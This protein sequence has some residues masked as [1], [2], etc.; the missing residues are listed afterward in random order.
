MIKS[1]MQKPK[2]INLFLVSI[3]PCEEGGFFA[4]CPLL[5]G[6]HAEGESFAEA[7]ENIQDVIKTHIAIRKE[8]DELIP[9]INIKRKSDFNV[10][11][12]L[13]IEC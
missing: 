6:C 3:Q 7:I 4:T 1:P 12:P 11:I 2:H 9:C 10:Q 13:P 8:N 5:Q